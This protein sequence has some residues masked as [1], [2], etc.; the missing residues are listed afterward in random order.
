MLEG[1]GTVRGTGGQRPHL[2]V[3]A[4]LQRLRGEPGAPACELLGRYPVPPETV[5]RIACDAALTPMVV[6]EAG[7][8]LDCGRT[9]R[10]ASPPLR[11]SV[12]LSDKRC[13]FPGCDRPAGWCDVHRLDD[14]AHGGRTRKADL[15]LVCRPHHRLLHEGGWRLQRGDGGEM[16]AV[17]PWPG[18]SGSGPNPRRTTA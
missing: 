10:T 12:V 6:D 17:P 18:L 4:S 16:V 11:R 9:M 14:W 5:Q 3:T 1:G 13:R 15:L 2:I 7:D 8:P